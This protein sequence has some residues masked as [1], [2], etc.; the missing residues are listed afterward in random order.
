[1]KRLG[2]WIALA[3][4]PVVVVVALYLYKFRSASLSDNQTLWGLF[5]DYVGG[6][7]GAFYG[8]LAFLGV[9]VTIHAQREQATA[10]QLQAL[11]ASTAETIDRILGSRPSHGLT[12]QHQAAERE[13]HAFTVDFVLGAAVARRLSGRVEAVDAVREDLRNEEINSIGWELHQLNS[14]LLHFTHCLIEF[15]RAGGSDAIEGVYRTRL[16]NTLIRLHDVG[17]LNDVAIEHFDVEKLR[18]QWLDARPS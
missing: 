14:E 11:L 5:G 18:Q 15:R 3:I 7:L 17:H 10:N 6:T 8:L 12:R 9:L 4:L 1:M 16:H 13:G 2:V